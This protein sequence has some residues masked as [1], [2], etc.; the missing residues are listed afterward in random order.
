M[1]VPL[2]GCPES[3]CRLTCVRMQQVTW[4]NCALCPL[5]AVSCVNTG[6]GLFTLTV[7]SPRMDCN[8]LQKRDVSCSFFVSEIQASSGLHCLMWSYFTVSTFGSAHLYHKFR[9]VHILYQT[10][11]TYSLHIRI[12]VTVHPE[13]YIFHITGLCIANFRLIHLSNSAPVRYP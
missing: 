13:C 1:G 5:L 4:T 3:E 9:T 12:S 8:I 6:L 10:F 2:Q 7:S 11:Y